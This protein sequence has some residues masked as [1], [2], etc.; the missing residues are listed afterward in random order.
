MVSVGSGCDETETEAPA[1]TPE[2]FLVPEACSDCHPEH[3]ADW[4]ASMHAQAT[5]DP[6][7]RAMNAR[8]IEAGAG[9]FCITCHAPMAVR[10]GASDGTDLDAVPSALRGVT[11]AFC[12]QVS[13]VGG[14]YNN[15]LSIELDG[16]M[17]GGIDDPVHTGAHVSAY[18]PL[19]DRR[20]LE[21]SVMCGSCHD[22]V[23]GHGFALERT[24]EEWRESIFGSP[25]ALVRASCGDCHM[26]SRIAPVAT[27]SPDR[28]LHGHMMP[29]VDVHLSEHPDAERQRAAVQTELEIAV[30]SRVCVRGNA[31]GSEV[32]VEL[33]NIGAGHAVPSGAGHYRRMWVELRAEGPDGAVLLTR[34]LE[35]DDAWVMREVLLDEAGQPTDAPWAAVEHEST[36]LMPPQAGARPGEHRDFPQLRR[37]GVAGE[38]GRVELSLKFRPMPLDLLEDLAAS[39]EIAADV[40]GRAATFTM[41]DLAWT[42]A[43][44][45]EARL[46]VYDVEV[47]CVER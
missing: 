42:S 3:Y 33:T 35:A 10:T 43:E 15:P 12:H 36:M 20:E 25:E 17:R 38:I 5:D 13:E 40:P 41:F 47:R 26:R 23:N 16:V 7:F 9:D 39:G 27:D 24:L 46:P 1:L 11:C 18:S 6:V 45:S 31:S 8:A 21:S 28:R 37:Y 22:V 44:A 2:Q 14:D 34:D 29:G 19:H 30:R 4:T 32:F